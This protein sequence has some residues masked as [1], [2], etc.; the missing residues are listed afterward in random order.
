MILTTTICC[1]L[2]VGLLLHHLF[3]AQ[4]QFILGPETFFLIMNTGAF[5]ATMYAAG[6]N[7]T[8]SHPYVNF[9]GAGLISFI[10]GSAA[11]RFLL[12]FHHASDLNRFLSK[13][14]VNDLNGLQFY[15][16]LAIGALSLVVTVVYFYALGFF[17][18]YNALQAGL[19][20]GPDSMAL[21]YR[22]L[23]RSTAVAGTY[24]G[25]GYVAQFKDCLL[26]LITLVL[27]YRMKL[28]ESFSSRLLF[29]LFLLSAVLATVGRG[30]RFALAFFGAAF[31]IIGV[32]R[33]MTPL[34]FT[35]RQALFAGGAFFLGLVVLTLMMGSRGQ[36][37]RIKQPFWWA[38]YQVLVRVFISP[39]HERLAVYDLYLQDEPPLWGDGALEE[40]QTI[41]PGR[42][43]YTLSTDLHELLYG[44]RGGNVALGVWGN[45]WRDFQWWGIAFAFPIGFLF[46]SFYVVLLRGPKRFLRVVTLLYAGLILGLA[47]D[48]QVLIL[49]G[50]VTC[51]VF[52]GVIS[53]ARAVQ[54]TLLFSRTAMQRAVK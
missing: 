40:L 10:L 1:A 39:A 41:L 36:D 29:L 54:D 53:T 50:F 43:A 7:D 6:E 4:G 3:V 42:R 13:P 51:I 46:N 38:P 35:R 15:V 47:T 27:Y 18:P 44:S 34:R 12:R 25:V 45:L 49:R 26:P 30:A 23:R 19:S 14:W 32:S 28:R 52:L 11:S 31:F 16:V 37:L 2:L 5:L 22:E 21:T 17:V 20:A 24:L 8:I 48:L 33:L 9:I